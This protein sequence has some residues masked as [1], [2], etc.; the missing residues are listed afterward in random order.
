MKFLLRPGWLGLILL[1]VLFASLCFTFLAPWQFDRNEQ[2]QTRNDNIAE[3]MDA[4]P[5]PIGEVLPGGRAPA[6]DTEW[7]EVEMRGHYLPDQEVL[8]WQRT[9]QGE[10]AFEV[11]VPFRLDDGSTVLVNRGYIRP[12]DG[13]RTPE[14][15]AAPSGPAEITARVRTDEQDSERRPTFDHDGHH[16]TYA[17]NAQTVAEGTGLDLRPGYFSLVENQPG[18]LN[19]L[20]LPRLESG[21]YFSYALQWISFGVMAIA[22]IGY[23]VYAELRPAPA[24]GP[25]A[26]QSGDAG[27]GANPDPDGNSPAAG[28]SRKRRSKRASV[29]EA[30]AEEERREAAERERS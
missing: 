6:E 19:P 20:P 2:A 18:V 3:S 22:A 15:A 14:Y 7:A 23:L 21:P 5:R 13:T 26:E 28:G 29:A 12:V 24:F 30:I 17:I 8:G 27:S 11:L 25:P 16:W 4:D 10:P 9:V 1:V